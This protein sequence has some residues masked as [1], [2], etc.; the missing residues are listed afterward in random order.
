MTEYSVSEVI[1]QA[2]QTEKLGFDF[3]T[4]MAK[5]FLD[6]QGLQDLFTTLAA[7]ERQHEAVFSD[8]KEKMADRNFE[9]WEE[10]GKY[11]RSIV[12]SEFFLGSNKSL[13]SL[14]HI[15]SIKEAVNF[16]IGFE[17]ETLLYFYH[18]RDALGDGDAIDKIIKEEQSHIVWLSDFR[19]AL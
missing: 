2:V 7:K 12:E 4:K 9:N 16:A 10:A 5:K 14:E 19:K 13:P 18:M 6:D 1:E 15:G 8:L 17:K 11:M 3:Y